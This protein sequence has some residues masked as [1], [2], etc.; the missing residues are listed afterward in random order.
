M[1]QSIQ[2][3]VEILNLFSLARPNWG[4]AE[5]SRATGLAKTTVHNIVSTLSQGGFL[6]Q[7]TETRKYT[8]GHKIFTLGAIM[9]GTMDINLKASGPAHQIT[10]R[11][12]LISRVAVWDNDA[13][14]VTLNVNPKYGS[15]LS[16]QIGPRVV[17]Y[18]SAIGRALLAHLAPSDL[19]IYLERWKPVTFTPHTVTDKKELL[20]IL[21]RTRR[22]GYALNDQELAPG[23]SAIAA[24]IFRSGGTLA[25]SICLTSTPEVIT[26]SRMPELV[27]DLRST[28]AEISR[29][30][31]HYPAGPA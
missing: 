15:S 16:Q 28:A 1:I 4:I 21:D 19:E 8:L 17:A 7:N 18:C 23:Q 2:R 13:A 22:Q 11:T 10:A 29:Y 3:A 20:R 26:G 27:A 5:I 9:A 24:A 14:L 6:L 30:L 31:G 12:G 25:A